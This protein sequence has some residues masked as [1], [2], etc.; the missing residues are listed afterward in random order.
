[1]QVH[2]IQ[3]LVFHSHFILVLARAAFAPGAVYHD[4]HHLLRHRT[5]CYRRSAGLLHCAHL[6]PWEMLRHSSSRQLFL[7]TVSVISRPS[8][9]SSHCFICMLRDPPD[10]LR[11]HSSRPLLQQ[12]SPPPE[13]LLP[14]R[15]LFCV[16]TLSLDPTF[17][18]YVLSNFRLF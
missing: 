12:L 2:F 14:S 6:E 13:Q 1:M 17:C 15:S 4:H 16:G 18:L 10:H 7:S 9:R 11:Q 8:R 3:N 5:T